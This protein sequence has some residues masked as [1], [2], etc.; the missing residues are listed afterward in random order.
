MQVLALLTFLCHQ[1]KVI[2]RIVRKLCQWLQVFVLAMY[3]RDKE[4]P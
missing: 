4:A 2:R 3:T 1:Y